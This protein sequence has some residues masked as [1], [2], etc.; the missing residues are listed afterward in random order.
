M[1]IHAKRR[2]FQKSIDCGQSFTLPGRL[3]RYGAEAFFTASV[4]AH[5]NR[6]T[7]VW[8]P[9]PEEAGLVLGGGFRRSS[10][11]PTTSN[12]R[13]GNEMKA[14]VTAAATSLRIRTTWRPHWVEAK[15]R[16]SPTPI[17]REHAQRRTGKAVSASN[18][19]LCLSLWMSLLVAI[20]LTRGW[21]G[22]LFSGQLFSAGAKLLGTLSE[23][24]QYA[25][26]A[27]KVL[28]HEFEVSRNE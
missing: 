5:R 14:I 26:S 12:Q 2:L 8:C 13:T 21:I 20:W 19:I 9:P 10:G 1:A 15:H 28:A 25:F 22:L 6:Q 23:R 7:S 27:R 24:T 4:L 11:E 18:L 17:L 3:C 16:M